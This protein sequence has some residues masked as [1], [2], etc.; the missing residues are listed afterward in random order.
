MTRS[1]QGR[2]D[3]IYC[4]RK[5][6]QV[7]REGHENIPRRHSPLSL[8]CSVCNK[9]VC[10]KCARQLYGTLSQ[11]RHLFHEDTNQFLNGLWFF[12]E[13][14]SQPSNFVGSCC[15]LSE[16]RKTSL[17]PPRT[18]VHANQGVSKQQKL[19]P[20]SVTGGCFCVP[21]YNLLI[22]TCTISVDVLGQSELFQNSP[23]RRD[24]CPL[25]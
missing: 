3:C 17:P 6:V 15:Y 18:H 25:Y 21:E 9:Q 12:S 8:S 14:Q 23:S 5:F 13:T 4:S 10:L 1:L 20:E 16:A 19:I 22:P 24:F 7:V 11:D 2:A